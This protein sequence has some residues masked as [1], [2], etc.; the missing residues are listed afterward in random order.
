MHTPTRSPNR[1]RLAPT[2]CA[3]ALS[4]LTLACTP[5]P[6]TRNTAPQPTVE[7]EANPGSAV[8]PA[9]A[10]HAV[11]PAQADVLTDVLTSTHAAT[12]LP[13]SKRAT[14]ANVVT[15]WPVLPH[16]PTASGDIYHGAEANPITRTANQPVS[17]FGLDVDSGSYAVVRRHLA[18][19]QLPPAAAVRTEEL[20]NYFDY[21]S[22]TRGAEATDTP[23]VL[24]TELATAPWHP[25]RY[26]LRIGV[27]AARAPQSTLPPA[28][29][30]FLIDVSGSMHDAD[31]L[32]LLQSA[33]RLLTRQLDGEDRV[34]I[35]TYAGHAAVVL[36]P[37]AGDDTRAI[38]SAIT[39]LSAGGSTH[40]AAGLRDAYRLAESAFI[41]G[42]IN[43]VMLATDGDFNVGETDHDALVALIEAKRGTG[44]ALSTMGLGQG[45]YNDHLMEQLADHGNGNYAYIDSMREASR[46]LET[47]L[48]ATL[49]TVAHDAK[50]QVE[51]NPATVAEYRLIGYENRALRE[52]DFDNDRVDAGDIGA[53]HSVTAL[54]ELALVGSAGT[55]LPARRFAP[56]PSTHPDVHALAEISLRYKRTTDAASERLSRLI[57]V[58]DTEDTTSASLRFAASVAAWGDWLRDSGARPAFGPAAIRDLAHS[59]LG[60]DRGGY[61]REFL[62][63]VDLASAIKGRS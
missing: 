52:Q 22:T 12:A 3:V 60:D 32:P 36:E 43:R 40:G 39:A 57:T 26:L 9:L 56:T 20:I 42:G 16:A 41:D 31:K 29:L 28:N 51:F 23:F 21:R 25:D 24:S 1:F 54:Y 6:A 15:D 30:V 35:V 4:C 49:H 2:A 48:G 44:I 63:L 62:E 18:H 33:M 47:E 59:A 13:Q 8:R 50:I 38:E 10:E 5:H 61:R 34:S 53:G 17:T 45:N 14:F 11:A 37:T 19:G 46:V 58:D 7:S 27:D 55:Q